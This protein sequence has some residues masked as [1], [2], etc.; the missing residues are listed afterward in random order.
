MEVSNKDKA[1]LAVGKIARG[2]SKTLSMSKS[3]VMLLVLLYGVFALMD[4]YA[5]F[6]GATV[7]ESLL[8]Y[9]PVFD[10]SVE[11]NPTIDELIELYPDVRA[12]LTIDNTN[13]DYPVVQA[14]NNSKYVNYGI[15]GSFSLS[16][17]IFLDCKNSSDF[18]DLY[19]IV[20]GHHMD[21]GA[22][23]GDLD[24]FA[25]EDYLNSHTYGTLFLPDSTD[26]IEIFAY[27]S[28][29]AYDEYIFSIIA[30]DEDAQLELIE[31][32]EENA[33]V[34]RDIDLQVGD[35]IVA[36]STCSSAGTNA[37]TVVLARL[38]QM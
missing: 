31:Y 4:T 24:N 25:D 18:T 35:R 19:N 23:F 16:G 34:Y 5:I 27:I 28:V 1:W 32:V 20:Y 11:G 3:L 6:S 9:K 10:T 2:G 8:V 26:E 37:R 30:D 21:M 38:V 33:G 7:D 13:I 22:M 12:W 36:F 15:D 29:S 14:E 17:A